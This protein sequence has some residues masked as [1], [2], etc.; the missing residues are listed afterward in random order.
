MKIL[1]FLI[2]IKCF[3]LTATLPLEITKAIGD[4]KIQPIKSY[5]DNQGDINDTTLD[6]NL[7]SL[8]LAIIYNANTIAK[9]LIEN[10]ADLE[11]KDSF[12]YT[13]LI[14]AVISQ[15]IEILKILLHKKVKLEA[16]NLKSR[17]AL[18]VAAYV[19]FFE[20]VKVL[21]S[22]GS[23]LHSKDETNKTPIDLARQYLEDNKDMNDSK[24]QTYNKIINYLNHKMEIEKYLKDALLL[25]SRLPDE[26]IHLVKLYFED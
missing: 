17:T 6:L 8:H 22:N 18:H 16:K 4:K 13:P 26:L 3:N 5:L 1:S 19:G 21:L 20:G 24:K 23:D 25:H 15:N 9:Y 7:S 11:L 10:G 12:G 14:K 2:F